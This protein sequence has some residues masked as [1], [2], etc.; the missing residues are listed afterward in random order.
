MR[1][2][3]DVL[4]Y[5]AARVAGHRFVEL[6]AGHA[7]EDGDDACRVIPKRSAHV[8][9]VLVILRAATVENV[10]LMVSKA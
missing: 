9:A 8:S 1:D 4:P 5:G 10:A 7:L 6:L 3:V 2:M